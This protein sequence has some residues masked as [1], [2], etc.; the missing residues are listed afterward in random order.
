MKTQAQITNDEN[1]ELAFPNDGQSILDDNFLIT[2][3]I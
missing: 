3:L 1:K 2:G